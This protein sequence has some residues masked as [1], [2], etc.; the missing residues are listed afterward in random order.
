MRAMPSNAA[1]TIVLAA[2]GTGGHLFP[3]EALARELARRGHRLVLMTDRRGRQF[4]DGF[5]ADEVHE[6]GAATIAAGGAL[7]R[8]LAPLRIVAG[9]AGAWRFLGAQRP[10]AVV[11]F[12]GYPALPA[13]AAAVLRRIPT[14]IH[15]Q[16]AVLGRVNRALAG[17]V[18]AIA[19]SF[20]RLA[21]IGARAA[22][23][24]SFTGNPVRDAV[25]T[26]SPT[27]YE[28]PSADGKFH[29][30]VFGGSLGAR[31]FA[32]RIPAAIA[33]LDAAARARLEVVQQTRTEDMDRVRAAYDAAGVSAELSP[34][35]PDMAQRIGRA[36][37]VIARAGAGTVAELAA[38][39]RPAL[40]VPL[41][42][43]MDDHQT[44]NAAL[45][46]DAGAAWRLSETEAR[47]EA[48]A[49]RL[50]ALMNAPGDLAR[51]A[52]AAAAL[53]RPH[54]AAALADLVERIAVKQETA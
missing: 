27:P 48:I 35:F 39:G 22:G 19:S 15:E 42:I 37:L 8:L 40:L 12:G 44:A 30:L 17:R 49:E 2:G 24:V 31:I 4:T 9:I 52:E 16:N 14:C 25:V 18:T 43:A 47:V 46:V 1:S 21:N 28:Q 29:L 51:A 5:P 41:A 50:G 33:S 54:A 23:R 7:A 32:D 10:A 20:P 34:F 11:G 36:H 13:M 3:A 53:G 6:I 26:V 38:I 45:L